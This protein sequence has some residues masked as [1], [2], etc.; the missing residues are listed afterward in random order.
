MAT[1]DQIQFV[2]QMEKKFRKLSYNWIFFF[3][4]MITCGHVVKCIPPEDPIKCT[5][6]SDY[7]NCTITNS[8]G[9]FPDRSTC[10]AA[11]A[12]YPRSEAELISAVANSTM[13]KKKMKVA[14]RYSHS[15]PK[16]VCPDGDQG[17]VIS[18][19]YLNR[20][21]K[22]DASAMTITVESGVTLRQLINETAKA[23][24]ALPY[25][26]YW[27][28]LT[29]GGMMGTGAHGSSL[30]G[31]G[32]QVHDYVIQLR[33]VSPAGPDDGYAKVRVLQTG[34][35]DF[36]AA[37]VSLGVL[38]V[39]SQVTLK[40]EALFK[41][42]V[43]YITKN[44]S[45]LG[46]EAAVSFGRAHEF[47]DMIWHPSQKRVVYRID[48]RVSI[49]NA[50]EA[51]N[52]LND[53]PGFR[54]TPSLVLLALRKTEETQE[55][56]GDE[57]G[58]CI[59][60]KITTTALKT[61]AYGL[62]NN[63][64]LFTGYPVIGYQNRM[65][66]SG[67]CLDSSEDEKNTVCPWDSRVKGLF[68]HQT[69]FSIGLSQVKDFI[70]DIQKLVSL[71][72]KALCGLDLYNGILMRYVTASTAYLGKQEDAIDFDITYYRSKNAST[73][74]LFQDILEEIE[75][76]GVFKYNGLPHWGKNRNVAFQGAI[77][78]YKKASEFIK[79]KQKYDPM[80]LFSSD[81]TDQ[82]L[83]LKDGLSIFKDGCALEGLC[84]CSKDAHC[85]PN[86]GYLC[87]PGKVYEKARVCTKVQDT[88]K[89]VLLNGQYWDIN[90]VGLINESPSH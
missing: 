45:S 85:A 68:Y 41:R 66:A 2:H 8:N 32:S 33:I 49:T 73:P 72:P 90:P 17:V 89:D 44:D 42:S 31:L 71:E 81:W 82:I 30:W 28:G 29:V 9:I 11:K 34:D 83:G 47:A 54:S 25:A 60:A 22:I 19:K 65:Q 7:S 57:D 6:G 51:S 56:L 53:F 62:T 79:I 36:D 27:W 15:I 16:L 88:D 67:T 61:V 39:I 46:D 84:I 3:L 37:K 43:T 24:L 59:T 52:G 70:N 20:V 78:K 35:P 64:N 77:D 14:T 21:L 50:S 13:A 26:P 4:M 76:I 23:K 48:D 75:Q 63:G 1:H 5:G 58:K 55:S 18:T 87:R 86:K 10:R 74:R 69:A 38:G 40:L 12:Y 80:A